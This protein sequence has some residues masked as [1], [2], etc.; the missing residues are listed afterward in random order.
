MPN[1]LTQ[2]IGNCAQ[3]SSLGFAVI[4]ESGVLVCA[5]PS[6]CEMFFITSPEAAAGC[7]LAEHVSSRFYSINADLSKAFTCPAPDIIELRLERSSEPLTMHI[8]AGNDLRMLTVNRVSKPLVDKK[9]PNNA[10]Q[11][12]L[13]GLGN[14]MLLND[15]IA[16]WQ[17]SGPESLSLAV[18]MIDLDRFK[19]INDT[20]GHGAGDTLLKLV[21]KRILSAT[22]DNDTVI[23]MEGDEFVVLH[24]IG[25][26]PI[27]AISVAKR[28]V[29][30]MS[31]SFLIEGQQTNIGASVGIAAL[32][33]GTDN[34]ADLLK[35][36]DL[37]LYAAKAA[38]R[39]IV[40]FFEPA[41]AQRA[42]DRRNLEIDL[43]RALGLKEFVL[44]YQ[45]QVN[46]ADGTLQGFEALIR[47]HNP[48]RGL[49][50][51]AD[52]IPLAEQTGEINAIGE[53]TLRTACK[54]AMSWDGNFSVAVNVSPIQFENESIVDIVRNALIATGL[55]PERLELEIT[56]GVMMKDYETAQKHLWAIKKMGVGIAM[57]DFGTGYSSLSY[58]NSFPFSKIKIDQS[59][60]RG[61]SSPKS[62]A[63]VQAIISLGA[64]LKMTTIA[65]G[66][67]TKEQFDELAAGGCQSAQ[68]Y[69]ISRPIAT[70]AIAGF[71][72]DLKNKP[73]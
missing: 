26:Q 21:A 57:D 63:L 49:V 14:R 58:L 46:M 55:A 18:I 52:F 37:A 51:P 68:G 25:F 28:I 6:F 53:W 27:G 43:S 60:V 56:E 23:R 70:P 5:N 8:A 22:R 19:K 32:N 36:A 13:T 35:H 38:G 67:E 61:E 29:E 59:F 33:H 66:V 2:I 24:T 50:S 64:S 30:L 15:Q 41:L 62:R 11:D 48:K 39:G 54:E 17:P 4:N 31:R 69:L 3:V 65:E 72:S 73:R 40:K 20:L 16:N 45:P 44:M 71:I 12:P 42:M 1:E 34:I 10:Y 9:L 7:A 47:W